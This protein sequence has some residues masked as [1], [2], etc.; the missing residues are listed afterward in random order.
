MNVLNF[1][2][3]SKL[4]FVLLSP[5][6]PDCIIFHIRSELAYGSIIWNSLVIELKLIQHEFA[7][8]CFNRLSPHVQYSYAMLQNMSNCA[9][10]AKGCVALMYSSLFNFTLALISVILFWKLLD[11]NTCSLYKRYSLLKI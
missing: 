11:L 1:A 10:Y 4:N 9:P 8:L 2:S 7:V 3:S 6:M 5:G